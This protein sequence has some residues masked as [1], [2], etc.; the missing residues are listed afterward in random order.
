MKEPRHES[1]KISKVVV[2]EIK[3]RLLDQIAS[4]QRLDTKAALTLSFIAAIIA[5]LSSSDWFIDRSLYYRLPI[6]TVLFSSSLSALVAILVRNYSRDPLPRQL[7][8]KYGKSTDE[9]VNEQLAY[10]WV[11]CF[12]RNQPSI[13]RKSLFVNIAFVLLATAIGI[14]CLAILL[15]DSTIVIE[16]KRG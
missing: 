8:L 11:A 10:N 13:K 1:I 9:A 14:I 15:T 6:L 16:S 5:G 2:S 4:I 3:E 7:L 12:E